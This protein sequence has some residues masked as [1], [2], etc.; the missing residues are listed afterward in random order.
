MPAGDVAVPPGQYAR[1]ARPQ[2]HEVELLEQ[3][4]DPVRS[5]CSGKA[6]H[7][8][9]QAEIVLHQQTRQHRGVLW[10]IRQAK[11][12][13]GVRWQVGDRLAFQ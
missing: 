10:K 11:T 2:G 13:A 9:N 5:L 6:A 3:A 1:Q 7:L 8:R 4:L 12:G